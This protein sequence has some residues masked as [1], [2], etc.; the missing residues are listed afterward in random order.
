[1]TCNVYRIGRYSPVG[2][3]RAATFAEALAVAELLHGAGVVVALT[4]G[5]TAAEQAAD[6]LDRETVCVAAIQRAIRKA[7]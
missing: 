4:T 2:T 7:A 5:Q 1:M 3:V 6:S